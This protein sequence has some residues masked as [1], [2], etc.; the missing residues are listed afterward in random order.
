MPAGLRVGVLAMAKIQFPDDLQKESAA[1]ALYV[2]LH[3]LHERAGW[4]SPAELAEMLKGLTREEE[5]LTKSRVYNVFRGK[6][7]VPSRPRLLKIVERLARLA[8]LP[9]VRA[10]VRRFDAL[11]E[12]ARS[13]VTNTNVS[14]PT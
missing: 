8:L 10:E 3:D 7:M 9:D 6:P 2:A 14:K 1:F 13:E 5:D 11:W 12:A 4:P